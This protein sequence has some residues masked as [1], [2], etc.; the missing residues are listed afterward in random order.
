MLWSLLGSVSKSPSIPFHLQ[1]LAPAEVVLEKK[2]TSPPPHH[3][4]PCPP[5]ALLS[6]FITEETGQAPSSD[7]G[8]VYIILWPELPFLL[9]ISVYPAPTLVFILC[10]CSWSLTSVLLTSRPAWRLGLVHPLS[11][12]KHQAIQ[13]PHLP[14]INGPPGLSFGPA[15]TA[16]GWAALPQEYSGELS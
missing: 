12:D 9:M 10:F 7:V 2:C 6:S 11:H 14:F 3:T 13:N 5:P 16:D 8:R 15:Y 1:A 4:R